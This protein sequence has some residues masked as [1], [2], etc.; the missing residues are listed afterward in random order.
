MIPSHDNSKFFSRLSLL[1]F[2][3]GVMLGYFLT[4]IPHLTPENWRYWAALRIFW[5]LGGALWFGSSLALFEKYSQFKG[6]ALAGLVGIGL[7]GNPVLDMVQGPL[8]LE[9]PVLGAKTFIGR[10][11]HFEGASW[12]VVRGHIAVAQIDGPVYQLETNGKRAAFWHDT[13]D[14]CLQRE[15]IIQAEVLRNL[16]VVLSASCSE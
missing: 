12:D 3:S 4:G 8:V 1:V 2:L 15:G 6:A 11:W 9:G 13:F 10:V 16:Q 7:C 5:Q 14:D